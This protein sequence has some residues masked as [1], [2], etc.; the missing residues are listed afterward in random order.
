MPPTDFLSTRV[1]GRLAGGFLLLA[2]LAACGGGGGGATGTPASADGDQPYTDAVAYSIA[3]EASLATATEHAAVTHHQVSVAGQVLHY[4]AT[5]GH[6]TASDPASGA[7]KASIFYIAYATEAAAGADLAQR[8][9]TFVLSGGPGDSQGGLHIGSFAPRRVVTRVPSLD[10]PTAPTLVDNA[11]TL[12]DKSDL[13]FLDEVG[14][15]WSE[16]IA[17]NTNLSLRGVDP[18][19]AVYRDFITRWLAV[20]RRGAS[21]TFV[22]GHSYGTARAAMLAN[23]LPPAGVNLRGVML[24]SPILDF[25]HSCDVYAALRV[26]GSCAASLPTFAAVAAWH[27]R[28]T[29]APA[30]LA[31][32][33]QD[34]R[35][36]DDASYAP[37]LADW[38]LTQRAPDAALTAQ[39]AAFTG[40]GAQTWSGQ[41]DLTNDDFRLLLV[42]GSLVGR[43]DSRVLVALSS[44]LAVGDPAGNI[45]AGPFGNAFM[46]YVRGELGY[47]NA[48]AY[49]SLDLGWTDWPATHAG[50]DVPDLVPDLAA[51]IAR[52]PGLHVL[53]LS[54]DY[55]LATPFHQ[56]E[57]DLARLGVNPNIQIRHYASGHAIYLDNAA[58]PL[59]KA[60]LAAFYDQAAGA[61]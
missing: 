6:L 54:G 14:T 52:D 1:L 3:P 55:D 2:G 32:F 25:G 41:M 22:L 45:L 38:L 29:P 15:G 20:N 46:D 40:I 61:P 44:P 26:V 51:A 42:P 57:L 5:A 27:G 17:P 16:A 7:P 31:T 43:T 23:L 9:V 24:E 59:L 50:L 30:D 33:L 28:A 60:D 4:V 53:A 37:A 49:E 21:P 56:A 58:R 12:L 39:L 19:V 47:A 36:F 34:A 18:D 11:E 10:E 8:P 48:S 13:V 35:S